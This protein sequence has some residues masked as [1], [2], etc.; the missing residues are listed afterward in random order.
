MCFG[1]KNDETMINPASSMTFS[2]VHC[3]LAKTNK[4]GTS[5]DHLPISEL[6]S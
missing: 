4:E 2:I 5:N 6:F 3:E 1:K